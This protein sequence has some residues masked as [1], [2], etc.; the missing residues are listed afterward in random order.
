MKYENKKNMCMMNKIKKKENEN[1]LYMIL[2]Y[3]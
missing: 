3:I 2:N 1:H